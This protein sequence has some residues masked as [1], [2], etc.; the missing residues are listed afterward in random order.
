MEVWTENETFALARSALR[1]IFRSGSAHLTHAT[2]ALSAIGHRRSNKLEDANCSVRYMPANEPRSSSLIMTKL[3]M[4]RPTSPVCN[5]T[6][7]FNLILQDLVISCIHEPPRAA[8]PERM[9]R[10][11]PPPPVEAPWEQGPRLMLSDSMA[12]IMTGGRFMDQS[13]RAT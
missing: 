9:D 10:L 1:S 13:H 7:T 4:C 5:S 6:S 12:G 11:S 8:R 2:C 3:L